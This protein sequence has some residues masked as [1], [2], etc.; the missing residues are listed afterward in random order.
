MDRWNRKL[1]DW[2][3]IGWA[4]GDSHQKQNGVRRG[5]AT[6]TTANSWLWL[7]SSSG[8]LSHR[9]WS[10]E[11]VCLLLVNS[12][13]QWTAEKASV[14]HMDTRTVC[15]S[16]FNYTLRR[17]YKFPLTRRTNVHDERPKWNVWSGE[18]RRQHCQIAALY[19]MTSKNNY[20]FIGYCA[21]RKVENNKTENIRKR[22]DYYAADSRGSKAFSG[23]CVCARYQ[24]G[25][26]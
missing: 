5:L 25:W 26:H 24:N 11:S 3:V 9:I 19:T 12:T 21:S 10:C 13:H 1:T 7:A 18:N 16:I 15:S 22:K 20:C 17:R 4:T 14:E 2:C 8:A 23:V 6:D